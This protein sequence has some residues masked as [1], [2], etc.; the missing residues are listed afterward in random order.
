[1]S[2]ENVYV[3]RYDKRVNLVQAVLKEDTKLSE[4][5]SQALA[6]KLVHTL[7]SVPEHVR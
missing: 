2:T 5:V 1:M 3:S 6:V 7:D 4:K